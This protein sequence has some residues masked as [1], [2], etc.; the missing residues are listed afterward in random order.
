[1]TWISSLALDR[2]AWL[3][4][5]LLLPLL[6]FSWRQSLV[7]L[8][9]TQRR[10]SLAARTL[11]CVLLLG[12]LA[13]A[14]LL[15]PTSRRVLVVAVDESASVDPV[16]SAMA[17]RFAAR[18]AELVGKDQD[19]ITLRFAASPRLDEN[20]QLET[21]DEKSTAE[22]AAQLVPGTS[23]AAD[24]IAEDR[25]RLNTNIQAAI[26]LGSAAVPSSSAG[27][28]VVVTDGHETR[29]DALSAA[30]SIGLPVDT[31]PLAPSDEPEVQLT[32]VTAPA[33]VRESEPFVLEI[34]VQARHEGPARLELF[35]DDTRVDLGRQADVQ[36]KPGDNTFTIERQIR[37][38][39]QVLFTAQITPAADTRFDNN[40]AACVVI[41]QGTPNILLVDEQADAAES[42]R[43]ALEEQSIRVDVRPSSGLPN[44]LTQMQP[45]DAIVLS[46]IAATDLSAAQQRCLDQYVSDLGGGLIVI[47]GDRAFGLGGYY[48]STLEELL[49]LRSDFE[50]EREKPS[51]AMV[52]VIDRSGSMGGIKLEL[53]K[54]AARAAV[55][56]LG[57]RDQI[58]V[59]A[60][61]DASYWV[62]PLHSAA[63][64]Q[65]ILDRITTV[66]PGGGTNMYPALSDALSA[67]T[68]TVAKLKHVIV[69]TDGISA[70]SDYG[71]ITAELVAQRITVS[72]VAIGEGADQELLRQIAEQGG[73]RYYYC[74]D[75]HS[76]P[77]VFAKETM[78]AGKSAIN[79]EPF[80]P[81]VVRR[82][83]A[84]RGLDLS[85][86]PP[87]LGY[88]T[89][90]AK[91][92]ADVVLSTQDGDPLLASW[93]YGLG[94]TVAF[95]SDA[96]SRWAAEWI[97]WPDFPAFWA[98]LVRHVMPGDRSQRGELTV[99]QEGELARVTLQLVDDQQRF[100]TTAVASATLLTPDGTAIVRDLTQT[101]PG[102]YEVELPTKAAGGY[103]ISVV[104]RQGE[105]VLFQKMSSTYVGYPAELHLGPANEMLLR[106]I[107]SQTAGV[108]NPTPEEVVNAP[109]PPAFRRQSLWPYLLGF[110]L[111]LF[112]VDV[113][114]RR[115]QWE[116]SDR[117]TP[118]V[119]DWDGDEEHGH[120]R[121][122]PEVEHTI[123]G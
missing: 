62:S 87:L 13:G 41:A 58:G 116:R 64:K 72:T 97:A 28:I 76:V 35:Q 104:A 25:H 77:Q 115:I 92:T 80:L 8:P 61:D 65:T 15:V 52:L 24:R 71:D 86:A 123:P 118:P 57:P 84:L 93:R 82:M 100:F 5:T 12:A 29:G 10:L 16:A 42:L 34:H 117:H 26:E 48:G 68:A 70:A 107:A 67:L 55:E 54:D 18:V 114:L 21:N 75:P 7:N 91:P 98:Q 3:W 45:F 33:Q 6:Y 109:W 121:V 78:T 1:M 90:R 73:G 96:N 79:E 103:A 37:D 112:V 9:K 43:W 56:L 74:A 122:V 119:P 4:A 111:L 95:T 99:V 50:K 102:R 14:S 40:R 120:A 113:A 22:S 94:T 85:S 27:R 20:D 19:V 60:F 11:I 39:R 81:V 31:V 69:L 83:S 44:E 2:P 106:Q 53:A 38:R 47:G 23:S 101:L 46:N 59:I 36:L 51:L 30:A 49:P 17:D 89:T 108:Y 66:S 105:R 63:D 88:V 110:S 32:G